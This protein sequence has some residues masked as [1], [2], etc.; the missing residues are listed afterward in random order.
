MEEED[1]LADEWGATRVTV[2]EG[3]FV[4]GLRH[5]HPAREKAFT[6]WN[7]KMN[8]RENNFG[9]RIDYVFASLSLLPNLK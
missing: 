7:T 1:S 5:L 3:Q 6:C 8:C 4:D 9:T 2:A